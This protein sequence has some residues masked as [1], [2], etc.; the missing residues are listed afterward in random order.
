MPARSS[1]WFASSVGVVV[2]V[3]VVVVVVVCVVAVAVVW[4]VVVTVVV[5]VRALGHVQADGRARID[6]RPALGLWAT[7]VPRPCVRRHLDDVRLE[8]LRPSSCATASASLR[9][10]VFGTCDRIRALRDGQRHDVLRSDLRTPAGRLRNHD[11][12][13]SR[14]ELPARLVREPHIGKLRLRL[15]LR[16]PDYCRHGHLLVAAP[17]GEVGGE[18]GD[19][20]EDD[21]RDDEPGPPLAVRLDRRA[22]RRWR[23]PRRRRPGLPRGSRSSA[24]RP[25][26]GCAVAT[27]KSH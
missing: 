17:R 22:G 12:G 13:L 14:A 21:E 3:C 25:E 26:A 20:R 4:V 16:Q 8:T 7:T 1:S 19:D 11:P 24:A 27:A 2:V 18:A 15:R 6:A 10:T 5:C 23:R 9:L